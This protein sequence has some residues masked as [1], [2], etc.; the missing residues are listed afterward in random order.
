MIW[1]D[2]IAL[3]KQSGGENKYTCKFV[4]NRTQTRFGNIPSEVTAPSMHTRKHY[5]YP[6]VLM[7]L[8]EIIA[9]FR[10]CDVIALAAN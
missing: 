6:P 5:D 1:S 3:G 8:L 4:V 9:F 2:N 10:Q 7:A